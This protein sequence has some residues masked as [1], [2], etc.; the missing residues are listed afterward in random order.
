[1][2]WLFENYST[3]SNKKL[4]EIIVPAT[5]DSGMYKIMPYIDVKSQN[6]LFN[7]IRKFYWIPYVKFIIDK[8]IKTQNKSVY[9]QLRMGIRGVDIRISYAENDFYVTHILAGISFDK[10]MREINQFFR[11]DENKNEYLIFE[12]RPD[13][14][15]KANINRK[16][17]VI[18]KLWD[19]I[20]SNPEF[21]SRIYTGNDI[22]TYQLMVE[23]NKNLFFM[24]DNELLFTD[25]I[26]TGNLMSRRRLDYKWPNTVHI[27]KMIE[28]NTNH[29]NRPYNDTR[30][31]QLLLTITAKTD[32]I[33]HDVKCFALKNIVFIILP[34]T[35]IILWLLNKSKFDINNNKSTSNVYKIIIALLVLIMSI[36]TVVFYR[37]FKC[38]LRFWSIKSKVPEILNKSYKNLFT[39]PNMKDISIVTTDFPNKEFIDKVKQ[40]N[41]I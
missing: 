33:I 41:S 17:D 37:N 30:F 39:N 24:V 23:Q 36:I 10:L 4:N 18:N 16:R 12:I 20:D 38:H 6:T 40:L 28:M 27:N 13:Y 26:L 21:K 8:W 29:L 31:K 35:I 5:H 7:I 3:F 22:P 1:M 34:I 32:T 15:N 25:N 14:D 19:K 2:G 9:D 11:E